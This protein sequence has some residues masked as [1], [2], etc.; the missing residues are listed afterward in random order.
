MT[1]NMETRIPEAMVS[2]QKVEP[3]DFSEV[4]VLLRLPRMETPR[5]IIKMARVMKP[6]FRESRGQLL[7]R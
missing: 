6:E 7:A 1:P 2:C 4:A 5:I 3:R